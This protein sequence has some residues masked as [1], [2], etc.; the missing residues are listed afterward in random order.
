MTENKKIIE[1]IEKYAKAYQIL[2]DLQRNNRKHIPIGD[3][4]T[5]AIGEFL[6]KK[7][8]KENYK[9]FNIILSENHSQKGFDISIEMGDNIKYFQIKTIS[10]YSKTKRTSPIKYQFTVNKKLQKL[11][12]IV[13]IYLEKD[14]FLTG[15][16]S[17]LTSDIKSFDK[18]TISLAK[19][20]NTYSHLKKKFNYAKKI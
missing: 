13:L 1:A 9:D 14:S 11:D 18:K 12:G 16:Y 10:E 2:D 6:A 3:Q 17:I 20:N 5:G 15:W 7:I 4:K 8:L 19:I